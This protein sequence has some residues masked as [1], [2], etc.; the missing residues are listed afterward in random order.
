MKQ[1]LL[2]ERFWNC[3]FLLS[4][5]GLS[6]FICFHLNPIQIDIGGHIASAKAVA[7][8]LFHSFNDRFFL[9][10]I[11]NLFYPPLEDFLITGFSIPFRLLFSSDPYRAALLGYQCYLLVLFAASLYS[12]NRVGKLIYPELLSRSYF[13][14]LFFCFFWADKVYSLRYQ[15]YAAIDVLSIGLSS[16]LL[17]LIPLVWLIRETLSKRRPGLTCGLLLIIIYSHLITAIVAGLL[18]GINILL[19]HKKK[20]W[21]VPLTL[22]AAGSA[23]FSLPFLFYHSY[24][25]DSLVFTEQQNVFLILAG[26]VFFFI[27]PKSR[28]RL[29]VSMII[30]ASLLYA[31]HAYTIN[32]ALPHLHYYRFESAGIL[33]LIFILPSL[34][35][36]PNPDSS[37]RFSAHLLWIKRMLSIAV[38]CFF[39]VEFHPC[40]NISKW[41]YSK[42]S[43]VG[44]SEGWAAPPVGLGRA[45]TVSDMRAYDFGL[46]SILSLSNPNY[47]SVKGLYWESSN[48][49]L[50][51]N[52]YLA[53]LVDL[54]VMLASNLYFNSPCSVEK[55]FLDDFINDYSITSLIINPAI[56]WPKRTQWTT[57][58]WKEMIKEGG[59]SRYAFKNTGKIIAE[60]EDYRAF[61][62]MPKS[63]EA[64]KAQQVAE[65][66]SMDS[67]RP[68]TVEN[69]N[70]PF[71]P[72][73]DDR[74]KSCLT[75]YAS[76]TR[77]LDQSEFTRFKNLSS[78]YFS[79][80]SEASP[81]TSDLEKLEE[82]KY[83]ITLPT[84]SPTWL[85]IKL[86]SLPGW[87][88]YDEKNKE[89]PL[90]EGFPSLIAVGSG[91]MT[92]EYRRPL[93]FW[94]GYLFSL[95]ALIYVLLFYLG[96]NRFS[97]V[98]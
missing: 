94:I 76:K 47:K 68:I 81:N 33:F 95:G 96:R 83:V 29:L 23:A 38:L 78:E 9:G 50:L 90:F 49:N 69:K 92:L 60:S 16:Q 80:A 98:D 39:Y 11:Q 36:R 31:R 74:F 19:S 42:P 20:E 55:C 62:L 70:T 25:V 71:A 48:G 84:I 27:P 89:W 66:I 3:I 91:K 72:V 56:P 18:V 2:V 87:H 57:T 26:S 44:V 8:G 30:F 46:E 88:W 45:F 1:L 13:Y 10:N 77:F 21:I 51:I 58:C 24:L 67:V 65:V 93:V 85:A 15:G 4:F 32:L 73:M 82:G 64:K 35:S 14:L 79:V 41:N 40:R 53:N 75:H 97:N 59:T 63:L 37:S 61:V 34:L 17:S 7:D 5:L 12:V 28:S 86:A 22:T 6:C 43:P 52:S 54:N